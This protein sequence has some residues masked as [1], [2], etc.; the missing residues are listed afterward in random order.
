MI[1]ELHTGF[2]SAD[3]ITMQYQAPL[4][5]AANRVVVLQLGDLELVEE[6]ADGGEGGHGFPPAISDRELS[7]LVDEC[8]SEL[9]QLGMY[10]YGAYTG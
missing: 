4:H 6:S 9:C 7:Q 8:T 3:Q 2:L 1:N 10:G 5:G